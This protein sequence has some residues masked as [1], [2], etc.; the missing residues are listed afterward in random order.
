MV[1]IKI[2]FLIVLRIIQ[3]DKNETIFSEKIKIKNIVHHIFLNIVNIILIC[4]SFSLVNNIISFYNVIIFKL[5]NNYIKLCNNY[6]L[7]I[8]KMLA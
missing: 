1:A 6:I 5:P 4:I 7:Y 8:L 2:S 3:L